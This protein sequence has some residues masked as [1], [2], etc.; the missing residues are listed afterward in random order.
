MTRFIFAITLLLAITNAWPSPVYL[1][2]AVKSKVDNQTFTVALDEANRKITHTHENGAA[3]NSEG[4]FSANKV[5]YKTVD[6]IGNM[7]ITRQYEIDRTT[8]SVISSLLAE[9]TDDSLKGLVTPVTVLYRGK[10]MVVTA[11]KRK[12]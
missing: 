8:L 3:F 9:P 11:P 12:F 7:T 6:L 2:C 5:T 10:C 4:F 1:K